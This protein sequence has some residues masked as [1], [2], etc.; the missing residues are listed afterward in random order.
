MRLRSLIV[1][2]AVLACGAGGNA[3]AQQLDFKRVSRS[4]DELLSYRWRDSDK[5]EYAANFTLTKDAIKEAETSFREFSLSAMWR[6]LEVD[7]RDEVF[8]GYRAH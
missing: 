6:Y 8:G 1:G 5:H 4:G 7:L 2:M 3:C